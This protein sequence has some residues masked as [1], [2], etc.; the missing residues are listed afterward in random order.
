[1]QKNTKVAVA[2]YINIL[3]SKE[4]YSFSWE[5][6]I[7]NTSKSETA[8]KREL[9]R[10]VSKGKV[11]N[12]R[13]GFYLIITPRYEKMGVLPI[14]LYVNKLFEYLNRMYYLSL[15][16][17]AKFHG[18]SHQ[19]IQEEY[20]ISSLPS[21]HDIRNNNISINFFNISNWPEK[22]ILQKKSDAGLFNISSVALTM[23]D[24]IHHHGK[25]GGLNRMLS[26]LEELLENIEM[27][28][29]KSLLEWYPHKS[30]IQ[31]FGFLLNELGGD[32]E[33]QMLI[34]DYLKAN[35]FYPVMLSPK[36]NQRPGKAPNKWKIDVNIKLESD[37]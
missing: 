9:S 8:I 22:N 36:N 21:L 27:N 23:A 12:L 6:I 31:R 29:L 16:S 37:L 14:E 35:S 33:M 32:G 17:A 11:V 10:L 13:K 28:D 24:L 3:L 1:V 2:E 5:E 25:L 30:T 34:F 20:I 15:Y 26:V 18:A 7:E 4:E 19:Q